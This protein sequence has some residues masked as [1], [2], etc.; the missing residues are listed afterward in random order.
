MRLFIR[1]VAG[2]TLSFQAE[3]QDLQ[4]DVAILGRSLLGGGFQDFLF[5]ALAGEMIQFDEHIFQGLKPP[6][7]S[8]L[9]LVRR[10]LPKLGSPLSRV[11]PLPNG[12]SM[13]YKWA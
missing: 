5:S 9:H 11:I 7:T 3:G 1:D 6:T 10:Q 8:R 13:A 4:L 12:L 2:Q